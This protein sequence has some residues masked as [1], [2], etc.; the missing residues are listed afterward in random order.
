MCSVDCLHELSMSVPWELNECRSSIVTLLEMLTQLPGPVAEN[1]VYA[2]LPIVRSFPSLRD[3]L[4]MV[5]RKALFAR[6]VRLLHFSV[7]FSTH[8]NQNYFCM[9]AW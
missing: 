2:V 9:P 6:L 4:I 8:L 7:S 3:V 5:L 1:V